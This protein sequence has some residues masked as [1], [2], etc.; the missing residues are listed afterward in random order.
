MTKT[1]FR[2]LIAGATNTLVTY[3]IYLLL[4]THFDYKISYLVSYVFGVFL[5]YLLNLKYVFK[6]EHTLAKILL[7][8]IIYI[9][10]YFT[11]ITVLWI[12]VHYLSVPEEFA[13]IF[14]IAV[15]VPLGYILNRVLLLRLSK[16]MDQTN[17]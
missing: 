12:S 1:T 5:A 11:G 17:V 14:G 6:A 4:L 13:L 2:Y 16:D 10:L 9:I 3:V 8:P 15:N 7:Y